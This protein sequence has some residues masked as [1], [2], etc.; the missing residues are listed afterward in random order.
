MTNIVIKIMVIGDVVGGP[1]LQ[2]CRKWIPLLKEKHKLDAVFVNGENAAKDGKGINAEDIISLKESGTTVIT[3]GNHA[4]DQKNVY[5]ALQE[6]DDIVRPIN[7]PS[8][9]PGKGY[10]FFFAGDY[11]CAVINVHGRVFIND[12]LDCPF[13]A[14]ESVL[15]FIRTKTN[16]IFVD[17]HG[18]ATSEKK[19]MGRFLDGKV[20]AVWGTHTHVQTADE[21]IFPGGTAFITDL[22]SCG[23]LYS[24]IGFEYEPILQRMMVHHKFGKLTVDEKGPMVLSGILISIDAITGKAINIERLRI[25]DHDINIQSTH[26]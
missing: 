19:T 26:K 24:V 21:M 14:M 4:W 13:K 15:S 5:A 10:T 16:L 6:R 7:F 23:A 18:E 25:V 22:G 11:R 12:A 1:G 9:C 3:T 2:L 20:S 17:F 8:G